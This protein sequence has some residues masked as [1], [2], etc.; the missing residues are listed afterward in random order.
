VA[1]PDPRKQLL[2][3]AN[4]KVYPA[5]SQKRF[6]SFGESGHFTSACSAM[7]Y[8]DELLFGGGDQQHSFTCEPFHNLVHHAV[9]SED[10]VSF[11]AERAPEEQQSEFF[12]S[13][14]RWCR[15]VM[16]KTGPDGA[17]WVVDMYRY[18][19]EHPQWLPKEG[20]EE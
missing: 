14:D 3:P 9:L 20:Q 7:I 8:R 15:P 4:P 1:P 5:T 6:H 18:M 2:L 11:H 17:L 19:I 10:G 16:A 13:E 12:T